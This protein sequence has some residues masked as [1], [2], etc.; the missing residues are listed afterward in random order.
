MDYH[1]RKK[2]LN[3]SRLALEFPRV[4]LI[5]WLFVAVTGLLAFFSLKYALFPDVTFPVVIIHARSNTA[6]N[7]VEFTQEII[8][9][10]EQPLLRLEGVESITS[11]SYPQEGVINILFYAGK[12][13]EV[14]TAEVKK[15][16]SSV[17][18]PP[19]TKL[20]VIPYNLNESTAI[21]Y[22]LT[23]DDKSLE[24]TAVAAKEKIIPRLKEI[25][26]VSSV[27]LLGLEDENN[28]IV[29]FNGESALALQVVKK[30]SANTLEI[31]KATES[32]RRQLQ[33]LFPDIDF[34]IAQTEVDYIQEA[35][36]AT[37]D[38]LW[39]AII[40]AVVVIFLFL[41]NPLATIITAFAIPLSL[42]GT[43]IVMHI[44]GFNLETITLLALALVI[45]IVVDDAIVQVENISR[46][47][48]GGETPIQAAI[49]GSE[50]IGLAILAA[51][52]S[53][54]VVFLPVAFTTGNL[55][56]FFKPF[57][58]T[59]SSSVI[60][61]LLVART[62]TPVLCRYWLRGGRQERLLTASIGRKLITRY[63]KLLNWALGHPKIII[64][65]T[66]VIFCLSLA[67]IPLIPRGFIPKLD[68]GEFNIFY[69]TALPKI[70]SSWPSSTSPPATGGGGDNNSAFNWLAGIKDNP[71]GFILRR[72]RRVGERIEAEIANI[73]EIETVFNLVG[74]RNQP[75]RGK[76]HVRLKSDRNK[77]TATIQEE[78]RNRLSQ[79]SLKG[80]TYSVEDIKFVD[81]GDSQPFSV[82]LTSEDIPLLYATAAKIKP[83]L[84]KIPG[85]EDLTVSPN[86]ISLADDNTPN[87]IQR[88]D[89]KASIT[90]NANLATGEAIGNLTQEVIQKIQPLLPEKVNLVIGGD[91]ARMGEVLR[92]FFLVFLVALILMLLT[93]WLLFGSLRE[94][95][96]VVLSLPLSMVGAIFALL[97]TQKDFGIIS[98]IGILFLLGLLDK[99]ALLLVDFINQLRQEGMSIKTAVVKGCLTRLRP[100]LMTSL[101]T[102]M[103]M[104]PIAIGIGAG[105]ELRQ[106][107]A[108]AIIGGLIT[109]SLLSL[110]FVPVFYS[111][112]LQISRKT[113]TRRV[114]VGGG[115]GYRP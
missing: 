5:F 25:T 110:V 54:A 82:S 19:Q 6:A 95:L 15:A 44:A 79:L 26:G 87:L 101:S 9:P 57:A 16:V 2:R 102:I 38:S 39:L 59:V 36:Q 83:Q 27:S 65:A 100:I 31:V 81:T 103:G 30:A 78:I 4:T 49:R 106:P 86:D 60:I 94:P 28:T 70:P 34:K 17:W 111:L 73:P 112:I 43:F 67:L 46:H 8:H 7:T 61:S 97:I 72:T 90:F 12:S 92:Q 33:P 50:E 64:S 37:I 77:N 66:I 20:E 24:E 85:L 62:L 109:S 107:M 88:L 47:L 113:K 21:T 56:Q 96:V 51:T 55:G 74:W 76:I 58:L 71:S 29:R 80:V 23:S 13:L 98:L 91:S 52:I 105:A 99:N 63:L 14:A 41:R 18:L 48:E 84:E 114:G 93:L 104:L 42:L 45:G 11:T 22:V 32:L 69:T 40:L 35:T 10:L 89:G 3:I 115:G 68:R 53:I 1:W 75:N 108:I